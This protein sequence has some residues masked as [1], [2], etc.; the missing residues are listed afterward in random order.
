MP[1]VK[2]NISWKE[3]LKS[4]KYEEHK[5]CVVC[6]RAVPMEQDFCSAECKDGYTK[7]DKKKGRTNTIQ[8]VVLIAVM[9]IMIVV[10][11]KLFG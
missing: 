1:D 10:V 9:V 7:A 11:P 4:R 6:G 8:M 3:S 2:K 5:H